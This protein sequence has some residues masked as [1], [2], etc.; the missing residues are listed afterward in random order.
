VFR[1]I[2][3]IPRNVFRRIVQTLRR[4]KR[5][6]P[7]LPVHPARGLRVEAGDTLT[8]TQLSISLHDLN[9]IEGVNPRPFRMRIPPSSDGYA[10]GASFGLRRPLEPAW[11]NVDGNRVSILESGRAIEVSL[12]KAAA[13]PLRTAYEVAER[14]LD[15]LAVESF[16]TTELDDSLREYSTWSRRDGKVWLKVVTT[17]RLGLLMRSSAEVRD[18]TGSLRPPSA[19]PPLKWHPSHAY[20]RRSQTTDNLHEAYR[21]LFLALEALLSSVYPWE[22][23]AG[24]TKWFRAALEHVCN[25]YSLDLSKY[26]GGAG[27]NPYRRFLKEQYRARRCALF[28]SKVSEGPTVPG[29]IATREELGEAIRK[30]GRLFVDL[31]RLITGAG[32]GGGGMTYAGFESMMQS[33]MD[34]TLYVS[35]EPEFDLTA[36]L[37]SAAQLILRADGQPGVHHLRAEWTAPFPPVLHRAGSLLRKDGDLVEA[38]SAGV[39]VDTQGVDVL[40]FVIQTEFANAENLRDWFL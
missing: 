33:Q 1:N 24:E 36:C 35:A 4:R 9:E 21:N 26:V 7:V 15:I 14:V 18:P 32:F 5:A 27:G 2:L 30:L 37:Q 34:S 22:L 13:D 29:D 16:R 39:D 12:I 20:F 31:S 6:L 25:G 40:E 11:Y 19:R 3:V 17:G 8:I 10:C 23:E 28:H 38:F